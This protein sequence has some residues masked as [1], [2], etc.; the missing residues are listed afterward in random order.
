MDFETEAHVDE[1]VI[2]SDDTAVFAAS[3]GELTYT[4]PGEEG[5]VS[6]PVSDAN[7]V[8]FDRNTGFH[9]HTFLGLFFLVLSLILTVG[10]ALLVYQGHAETRTEVALAAFLSLFAIGGW[11]TTYDFLSHSNRDVI[12]VYIT[13]EAKTHVLCG[14]I[15]DAEFVNACQQLSDS[16]IP[17]SN[18]NRKLE[19][20]L[21]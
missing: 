14:E 13:T 2:D 5:M 8:E 4:R 20:T 3:D 17:T 18:R 11:N 1:Y 7:S 16:D 19:A 9:R 15:G 6:I 21:N 12:D 10:T